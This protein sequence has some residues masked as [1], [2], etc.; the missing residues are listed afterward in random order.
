MSV[1]DSL[2]Y[3]RAGL[4]VFVRLSEYEPET[5]LLHHA[6]GVWLDAFEGEWWT[7][8]QCDPSSRGGKSVAIVV[9]RNC[10]NARTNRF[11]A[12]SG[13]GS[14]V[15]RR[16]DALHRLS[17]RGG[18]GLRRLGCVQQLADGTDIAG[19]ER[20]H[21][22]PLP[23]DAIQRG[24]YKERAVDG[25]FFAHVNERAARRGD[26]VPGRAKDVG[27]RRCVA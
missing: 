20:D 3:L 21:L 10:T 5:A 6:A 2:H 18:Q 15:A 7:L 9:S 16:A 11:G 1:P 4:P 13:S 12:P 25:Q 26:K 19:F 27:S 8:D 22:E 24:T 14:T 23:H 17:R